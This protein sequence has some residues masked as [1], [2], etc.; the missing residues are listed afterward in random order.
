ME[1]KVKVNLA[2]ETQIVPTATDGQPRE[3]VGYSLGWQ[4]VDGKRVGAGGGYCRRSG[5][6]V[7][8]FLITLPLPRL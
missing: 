7:S 8:V 5:T 6:K 1:V 3:A 4:A 2:V